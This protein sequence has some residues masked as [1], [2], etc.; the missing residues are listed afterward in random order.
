MLKKKLFSRE[1][2]YRKASFWRVVILFILFL[3]F[4]GS[5]W[6]EVKSINDFISAVRNGTDTEITST[7][8]IFAGVKLI[9]NFIV[10]SV[11]F[12]VWVLFVSQYVLPVQSNEERRLVFLRMLRYMI[13]LHGPAVF[14]EKGVAI[15]DETEMD[16]TRPGVAFVDLSS[17]IALESQWEHVDKG[18]SLFSR[19]RR[20]HFYR[21]TER[22]LRLFGRAVGLISRRILKMKVV[23]K[24]L[25]RIA[26]PGIVFTEKNEKIREIADLRRQA[27]GAD[28]HLT[29][30]DGFDIQVPVNVVFSL[31]DLPEIL[32]VTYDWDV[33]GGTWQDTAGHSRLRVV[34]KNEACNRIERISD[35]LD[36]ADQLE[37]HQ[38]VQSHGP[39]GGD[40]EDEIRGQDNHPY[41]FSEDRIFAALYSK[42]L[43]ADNSTTLNWTELPIHLV[44]EQLRNLVSDQDYNTLIQVNVPGQ[45]PL[46][47]RI[48]PEIRRFMRN[49]GV[50]AYQF[51]TRK[52]GKPMKPGDSWIRRE[53][54]FYPSQNLRNSKVLRNRGIRIIQ[55]GFGEFSPKHPGVREQLFDHWRLGW[56]EQAKELT[57]QAEME[58]ATIVARARRTAYREIISNLE[59]A[60]T[61]V[62]VPKDALALR[63]FQT[64]EQAMIDPKTQAL[65]PKE[66]LALLLELRKY[67]QPGTGT[68]PR[69]TP[70]RRSVP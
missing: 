14:I 69:P 22:V 32:Y 43:D 6:G 53:L 52:D 59:M 3:V 23:P 12:F 58:A 55:A 16:N 56:D 25:V 18:K 65:L 66:G 68:P 39:Q 48:L 15:A 46:Y 37:I 34:Q 38:Y 40:H 26:G 60:Y 27:R 13:G 11:L 10:A 54:D 8:F 31:G 50:L 19:F 47:D 45:F 57:T 4:L 44:T 36:E 33:S 62:S 64:I 41:Y 2:Y 29:T 49:Q 17:A 21:I 1:K 61:G 9:Y 63:L 42:A 20:S 35:D 70:G 5:F 28:V 7:D 24:P 51:V 67:F 30:R